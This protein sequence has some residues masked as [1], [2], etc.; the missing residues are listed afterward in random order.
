MFKF[1]I[2]SLISLFI[3]F[4]RIKLSFT[5]DVLEEK[6]SYSEIIVLIKSSEGS[7]IFFTLKM[8]ISELK[9]F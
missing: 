2:L 7:F 6:S 1:L 8:Y 4:S 5:S 3:S 9:V